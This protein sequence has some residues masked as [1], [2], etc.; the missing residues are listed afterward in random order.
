MTKALMHFLY[1]NRTFCLLPKCAST[2]IVGQDVS[3]SLLEQAV[4]PKS[5][6]LN[7]ELWFI[8]YS[9]GV[10]LHICSVGLKRGLMLKTFCS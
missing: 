2:F 1:M 4:V 7:I 6:L 9:V 8:F 10:A 3:L 5:G